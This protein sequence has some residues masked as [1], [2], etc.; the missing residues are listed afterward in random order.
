MS[1]PVRAKIT[2]VGTYVPPRLLTNADLERLVETSHDWI[3]SR[4][5]ITERHIVEPGVMATS[6]MAVEASRDC[7]RRRGL[8]DAAGNPDASSVEAILVATVTPDMLFPSTAC[9]V[10]D[11]LGAKCWGFDV[12]AACSGFLYALATGA[13]LIGAGTHK[14]VMVIGA[15]TMSSIIDYTDR[16]TC[17]LF[18][19]GAGAVLLEAAAPDEPYGL[20]DYFH[21]IEGVGGPNLYMPAGGSRRPA[22]VETVQAREHFVHQ[23]GQSVFKYAVLKMYEICQAILDRNGFKASDLDCFIPH[24]AN[25]R[26]IKST[27]ERLGLDP[28]KVLVNIGKF[29]NTTAATIPLGMRDAQDQGLLHPNALVLLAA[30]GA[31][32]TAGAQLIRW[33]I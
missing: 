6:D 14:R 16:A 2:S 23:E 7:L 26:I 27:G 13:S 4:T 31:G 30:V 19:D 15:D 3:I 12:V 33:A 1:N 28:N 24:Q 18:G 8:I 17:V 9:L 21:Q 29:G 11:K 10:Q 20:L 22:S 25:L 5:G 32:Y